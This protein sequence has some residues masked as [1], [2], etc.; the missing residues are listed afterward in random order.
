MKTLLLLPLLLGFAL[1]VFAQSDR[2][3]IENQGG[4]LRMQKQYDYD[5]SNRYNGYREQDGSTRLRNP[6]TGDTLRGYIDK[7]GYGRLRDWDGNRYQV[8]P[9]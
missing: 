3:I 1:P 6:S 4:D 7:D 9:R 8:R 2:W 5:F